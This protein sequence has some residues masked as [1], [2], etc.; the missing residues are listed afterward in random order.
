[1]VLRTSVACVL[2]GA[3]L[4]VSCVGAARAFQLIST[5][6]ASKP[7]DPTATRGIS[8]GP[9]VI[10]ISPAATAGFIKS[11]FN[12]R[13]KFEAF[14]GAKIDKDMIVITYRKSPSIDLTQRLQP[15]IGP[16]GI[17]LEGAEVPPGEHRIR[18]DVKDSNGRT[19]TAE[20]TI[21]V[22]K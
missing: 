17:N 7:E 9:K 8:R 22:A 15:Y 3:F 4:I 21:K 2:L 6:E 12:W 18:I 10:P 1:M 5:D 20:M 13:V 19:S 16:A 14:G 11:P